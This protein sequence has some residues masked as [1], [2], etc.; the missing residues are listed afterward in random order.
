MTKRMEEKC[1]MVKKK[2]E[3]EMLVGKDE[4]MTVES[5]NKCWL[6]RKKS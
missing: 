6:R 5:E 4:E 1:F 3:E 2:E